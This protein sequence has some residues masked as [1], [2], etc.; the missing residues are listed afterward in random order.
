MSDSAVGELVRRT[1]AC[2]LRR[3]W[4]AAV[5]LLILVAGN[6]AAF[7]YQVQGPTGK[8]QKSGGAGCTGCHGPT[9]PYFQNLSVTIS[10]P[11]TLAPG[12]AGTYFVTATV[13]PAGAGQKMGVDIAASDTPTPLSESA[14]NLIV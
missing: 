8:T 14:S 7:A 1:L 3:T 10:G 4:F 6:E 12:I 13:F 9:P 11:S 5:L 2:A